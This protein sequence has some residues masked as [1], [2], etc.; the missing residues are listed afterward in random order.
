MATAQNVTNWFDLQK[1]SKRCIF[2]A[3]KCQLD[4]FS[5]LGWWRTENRRGTYFAPPP[6]KIGL[7]AFKTFVFLLFLY[8]QVRVVGIFCANFLDSLLHKSKDRHGM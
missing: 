8:C 2:K 4:T 1:V 6:G 7:K 5:V 3:R